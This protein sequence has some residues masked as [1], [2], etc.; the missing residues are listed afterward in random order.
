MGLGGYMRSF[1]NSKTPPPEEGGVDT[2]GARRPT[3]GLASSVRRALEQPF[4]VHQ[5]IGVSEHGDVFA[6]LEQLLGAA[7]RC[8]REP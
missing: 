3:R 7:A 2:P 6:P 8:W 5:F 1:W 4:Q